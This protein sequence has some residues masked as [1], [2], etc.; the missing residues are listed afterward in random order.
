MC[1]G[2]D[3]NRNIHKCNIK[4]YTDRVGYMRVERVRRRAAHVEARGARVRRR[5]RSARR[6][7]APQRHAR[8]GDA[9]CD[10]ANNI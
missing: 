1:R 5:A 3:S 9:H 8:A 4:R 2:I 6:A 7:A 10:L